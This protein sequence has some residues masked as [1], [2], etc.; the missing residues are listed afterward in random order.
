[1]LTVRRIMKPE[2]I[3]RET[4]TVPDLGGAVFRAYV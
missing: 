1:M 2:Q 4:V 3:P